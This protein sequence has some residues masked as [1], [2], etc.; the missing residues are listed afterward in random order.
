[1]GAACQP[2]AQHASQNL[3]TIFEKMPALI[4]MKPDDGGPPREIELKLAL[5]VSDRGRLEMLLK[6]TPALVRRKCVRQFLHNVY[7]DT[8]DQILRGKKVSLRLRHAGIDAHATWQQTLKMGG[9]HSA[10]SRRGEWET[11]ITGTKLDLLA[12]Q[13]TPW[14]DIDR[15]GDIFSALA[16]CFTTDFERCSWTVRKRDASIV[17]VSLDIGYIRA[18]DRCDVI[19]ELELE[20]LAGRPSALFAVARQIAA[21]VSLL[22]EHRSKAERGY[23]LAQNNLALALHPQPSALEPSLRPTEAAQRLLREMFCQ[24]TANLNVLRTSD[25]PE[26][27]HQA[28]VG[29]RRFKSAC[30]FFRQVPGMVDRPV[31]QSLAP[32]LA[33]MSELRDLDVARTQTLPCL[34]EAYLA[35]QDDRELHWREMSQALEQATR[36]QRNATLQSLEAHTAGLALLAITQWIEALT[37]THLAT[38]S[39]SDKSL[40][41]RGWA[42]PGISGLHK[43]LKRAQKKVQTPEDQH[44]VRIL[45]KRLR[46]AIEALG[47]ILPR[48][49]AQRWLEQSIMLQ[50]GMGKTRD[51]VKA[52]V[53]VEKLHAAPEL[54][55]FLQGVA[56]G[57]RMK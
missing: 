41:L 15:D 33:C 51:I 2:L 1:M 17:E 57:G 11:P 3:S 5:P 54:V 40:S 25:D 26:V 43:Q 10:L 34:A 45:A 23:A 12:L 49:G 46:Y 42:R 52:G 28:R 4:H 13:A 30:R 50:T 32:L 6:N 53:I 16:P 37:E 20:L 24:F 56:V 8:A 22:P 19:C 27:V 9:G 29:W 55:A 21:H 31:L 18:A 14:R 48:Q 44:R 47:T 38:D 39:V 36:L 7:Y 35:G